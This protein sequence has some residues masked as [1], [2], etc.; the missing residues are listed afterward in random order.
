MSCISSNSCTLNKFQQCVEKI[1]FIVDLSHN[2]KGW[3]TAHFIFATTATVCC[4]AW[5]Y[6]QETD[7]A[8]LKIFCQK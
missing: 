2:D 7:L 5:E 6:S 3:T 8:N 1:I 4:F